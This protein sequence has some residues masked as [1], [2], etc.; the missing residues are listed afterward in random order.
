MR[1]V[2]TLLHEL[3]DYAGLFP[4]AALDMPTAVANYAAYR[5]EP[6]A[7]LLGRFVVPATR[8]DALATAARPQ[9]EESAPAA[10][11]RISAL[12]GADLAADLAAIQAFNQQ[13]AGLALIDTI[14]VRAAEVIEIEQTLAAL[15]AWLTAYVELP[16]SAELDRLIPALARLGGRAKV[17]TGGTTADAFPATAD[18]VRFIQSCGAAGVP[19]KAT[20]GLHH[21][22][23]AVQRLT[24]APDSPSGLMYGFLNVFLTAALVRVGADA[25]E[26]AALLEERDP[27]ALRFDDDGVRWRDRRVP[28]DTLAEVRQ[29]VA[30]SFGSCSFQEP[31]DDLKAIHLL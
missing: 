23:R 2:D 20:A 3:I 9:F 29:H 27:G 25:T 5:R 19:F 26:A 18:L 10:P 12:G 14:E 11:W 31:V 8:L 7:A 22:L 28:L 15:P 30:L 17:R 6:H 1:A 21:P 24:Y 16:L 13:Q 4:P